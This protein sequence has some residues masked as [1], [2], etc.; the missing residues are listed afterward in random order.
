MI[1]HHL[2]DTDGPTRIYR[3]ALTIMGGLIPLVAGFVI[4]SDLRNPEYRSAGSQGVE[5]AAPHR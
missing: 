5:I 4:A 2:P 3:A 1:P